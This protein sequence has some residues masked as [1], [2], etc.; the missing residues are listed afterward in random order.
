MM[1]VL[2][3]PTKNTA[4]GGALS[5]ALS[6][7]TGKNAELFSCGQVIPKSVSY[8]NGISRNISESLKGKAEQR[9]LVSP[10]LQCLSKARLIM[11][12]KTKPA[13]P[14]NTVHKNITRAQFAQGFSPGAVS[15]LRLLLEANKRGKMAHE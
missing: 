1:I 4:T 2:L 14:Q 11:R 8:R 10:V 12:Q 9:Q 3:V 15:K 5:S 7:T 13:Q 6:V